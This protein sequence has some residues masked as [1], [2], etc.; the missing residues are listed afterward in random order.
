MTYNDLITNYPNFSNG[1]RLFLVISKVLNNMPLTT[2]EKAKLHNASVGNGSYSP[3]DVEASDVFSEVLI[4]A[5]EGKV[6]TL[7]S[8]LKELPATKEKAKETIW[9]I[10]GEVVTQGRWFNRENMTDIHTTKNA[11][12]NLDPNA[13]KQGLRGFN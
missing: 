6:S 13:W 2:L 10:N 1:Q 4:L 7:I 12:V 11:P 9:L 3:N 8:L 5:N